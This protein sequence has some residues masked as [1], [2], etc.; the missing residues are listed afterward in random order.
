MTQ[1][2]K[3]SITHALLLAVLIAF[4]CFHC[5]PAIAQRS[6]SGRVID[7]K[8]GEPVSF[9]AIL[10]V[11][12]NRGIIAD[13]NGYYSLELKSK[14]KVHL[15][16]SC[17]GYQAREVAVSPSI[18]EFVIQLSQQSICL[19]EFTVT[20]KFLNKV[21]SEATIS[22]EAME[23]IQPTSL[24]DL[25]VLLP[26]GKLGNTHMQNSTLISSRQVGADLSTSFG[27]G[28]SIN[29]VPLQN[30]GMRM[31]LSGLTGN[32]IADGEGNVAVNSGIDLRTLSTDHIES[33]TI[34]RGI[35]SAS[36]GN[37]SSGSI[38]IKS[39]Q[40][41][42]PLT[43]RVKADPQ[44]KLA[45]VG[46]GFLLSEKMGTLYLGADIFR[47]QSKIEDRRGAYN[48]VSGEIN[49]NN[50]IRWSVATASINF[51]GSYVTSFSN[52]KTDELIQEYHEKY[53][54][55][56]QRFNIATNMSVD[57][58]R[59]WVNS[60]HLILSTDYVSSL[61][62]HHKHVI[63]R[64][65]MPVQSSRHEGESEGIFLPSVYD[66][67]YEMDN[68]PLNF[69]TKLEAR[70]YGTIGTSFNT[71][72][73]SGA[74]LSTTKNHG[75]G[76]VIDPSRPPFPSEDFIRPR[77]NSS[78]PAIGNMAAW[79]E[80]KLRYKPSAHHEVNLMLGLRSV[81][82]LNLPSDYF[83]HNRFL[84]EPR[85]QGAYTHTATVGDKAMTNS[86]RLGFGVENKLPSADYLY[87]DKIYHDFI[88]LNAY[89]DDESKRLLITN[90][91]IQ[92]P[93]NKNLKAN[94]NIKWETGYDWIWNGW[95]VNLTAFYENMSNGMAYF[96]SYAPAQYTYYYELRHPV[97]QKPTKDD[98]LSRE[99]YTFIAMKAPQNSSKV[100][101]R[102]L[103]Y[104]IH[105]PEIPFIHSEVEINGAYY[106]TMYTSGIPVM[107]R[108]SVM[109]GE[110]MY[111]Y[112]GIYDGYDRLYAQSFNT[113]LWV[114][115]H[116]PKWKLIFT[117]FI[118]ITW[119]NHH[120][121][122]TDVDVYP[123]CYMD[124]DGNIHHFRLDNDP[125]LQMLERSFLSSRYK[126]SKSPFSLVWNIK[127]TKE[128]GRNIKLSFFANN[129][130]AVAPKYVN[131]YERTSRNWNRPFCG[132]EL[133]F[134][135]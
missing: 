125:K 8:S 91:K 131:K 27:M 52:N 42:T 133:T 82:M 64:T 99:M 121:L 130:I 102:G 126:M 65:V 45:Y 84:L 28:V 9:A 21:G 26:G 114:N 31:Q 85:L 106:R 80:T 39:K 55:R 40:G 43:V 105:T 134:R 73:L 57:F 95:E 74:S 109:M 83:L 96:T 54:S 24:N 34:T 116:L 76:A 7:S 67:Y 36:E 32:S 20:A 50:Q 48:R 90:T 72:I 128:I 6:L 53:N 3:E 70:H 4:A 60:L 107:Y 25:F 68:R 5:F 97:D 77:K 47:S 87:P 11:E 110:Q 56:Y 117:N 13:I 33:I 62:R 81:T 132:T 19:E 1:T 12:E 135:F 15:R 10:V 59:A 75:E 22:Q 100:V 61:L 71:T 119:L 123:Q 124:T 94:K 17:L 118:Q 78:M 112:V 41:K 113:N 16:V 69:F 115:T 103:E 35:S 86:F 101:K 30:D 2:S 66:T 104:R 49:W 37:L 63:N 129:I 29:G 127:A 14:G 46:K 51:R 58:Q 18:S 120:W 92:N 111:P 98:F 79:V 38:R 44:N 93:T 88:A 108:P 23:Y 122:S 89:F